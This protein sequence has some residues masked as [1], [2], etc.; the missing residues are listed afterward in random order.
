MEALFATYR[1]DDKVALRP[2]FNPADKPEK[3]FFNDIIVSPQILNAVIERLNIHLNVPFKNIYLYEL[4]RPIPQDLIRKY[5]NYPV[6]Y[7]EIPGA[8]FVEKAKN[9]LRIGLSAPDFDHPIDM[10]EK[11]VDADGAP[12]TCYLPKVVTQ[13]EHLINLS[14]LKFHQFSCFPGF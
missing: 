13:C 2:N 7:V 12:I 8:S 3:I 11:I 9:K 14:V 5:I 6:N 1:S 10:R 4:T